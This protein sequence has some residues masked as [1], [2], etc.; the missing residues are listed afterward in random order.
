MAHSFFA[1][2]RREGEFFEVSEGAVKRFFD[3]HITAQYTLE[4]ADKIATLQG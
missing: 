1:D 3:I 4:V 2:V